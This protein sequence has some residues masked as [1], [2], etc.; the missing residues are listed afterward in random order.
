MDE[1]A[2]RSVTVIEAVLTSVPSV[3]MQ[4][5]IAAGAPF[6]VIMPVRPLTKPIVPADPQIMGPKSEWPVWAQKAPARVSVLQ[7][8]SMHLPDAA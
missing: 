6:E 7:T 3:V 5:T 1:L 8:Q 4:L 2:Q